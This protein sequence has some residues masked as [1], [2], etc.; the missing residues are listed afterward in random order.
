MSQ[1]DLGGSEGRSHKGEN[2]EGSHSVSEGSVNPAKITSYLCVCVFDIVTITEV[3]DNVVI[4]PRHENIL[5]ENSRCP[6]CW[7]TF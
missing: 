3:S 2:H 7:Y 4:W 5:F 1:T 6:L